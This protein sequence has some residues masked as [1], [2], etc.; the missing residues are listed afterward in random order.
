MHL[1]GSTGHFTTWNNG[2]SNSDIYNAVRP[3]ARYLT[4]CLYGNVTVAQRLVLLTVPKTLYL[5][6]WTKLLLLVSLTMLP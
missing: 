4:D 1:E 6:T 2:C 5:I 3:D